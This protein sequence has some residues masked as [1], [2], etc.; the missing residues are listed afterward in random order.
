[1]LAYFFLSFLNLTIPTSVP[2]L[3]LESPVPQVYK[4]TNVRK[5]TEMLKKVEKT[6]KEE[7]PDLRAMREKRDRAERMKQR[8][9]QQEQVYQDSVY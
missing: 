9:L 6:K 7:H 3:I 1:M 5:K 8:K 2:C 4:L